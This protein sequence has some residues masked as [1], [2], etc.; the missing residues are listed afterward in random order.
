MQTKENKLDLNGI[1]DILLLRKLVSEREKEI[2][3]LRKRLESQK[4]T[5]NMA[6]YDLKS[7]QI[8][9]ESKTRTINKQNIKIKELQVKIRELQKTLKSYVPFETF[10]TDLDGRRIKLRNNFQTNPT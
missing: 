5:A 1:D 8:E 4:E 7:L 2:S 6:V 9:T 3:R 10:G